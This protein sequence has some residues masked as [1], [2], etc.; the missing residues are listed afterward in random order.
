MTDLW[1][2]AGVVS[3]GAYH[4]NEGEG[5]GIA[6]IEGDTA[7]FKSWRVSPFTRS[8]CY[9]NMKQFAASST[10]YRAE[11]AHSFG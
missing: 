11:H 5:N 7:T 8:S 9:I 4:L 2:A 6:F 3:K 10:G 1:V